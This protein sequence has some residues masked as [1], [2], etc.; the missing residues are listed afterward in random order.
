MYVDKGFHG[1]G[2]DK[3]C[4]GKA[5]CMMRSADDYFITGQGDPGT[6][7]DTADECDDQGSEHDQGPFQDSPEIVKR[8]HKKEIAQTSDA[9]QA[10]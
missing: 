8:R 6:S 4:Q 7:Q 3:I 9:G 5:V 10:G 2:P 1:F